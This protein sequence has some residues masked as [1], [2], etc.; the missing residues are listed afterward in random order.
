MPTKTPL[1]AVIHGRIDR[2]DYTVEK[3]YFEST[4][5]FLVTGNLYR[6]KN[7]TGK[8]PGILNFN[9]AEARELFKVGFVFIAVGG[10]TSLLVRRTDELRAEFKEI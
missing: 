3:A 4:P 10:D 9:T 7:V 1:R 6:P 5:G 2:G 8:A